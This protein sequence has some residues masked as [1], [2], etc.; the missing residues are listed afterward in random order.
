MTDL[1]QCID[2]TLIRVGDS[3]CTG[4]IRPSDSEECL[5]VTTCD[6]RSTCVAGVCACKVRFCVAI[7]SSSSLM[8]ILFVRTRFLAHLAR[9][10]IGNE[11]GALTLCLSSVCPVVVGERKLRIMQRY[12][13]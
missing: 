1:S 8:D 9:S 13:Q 7:W 6:S 12:V 10:V 4:L 2:D 3:K 5:G 11:K